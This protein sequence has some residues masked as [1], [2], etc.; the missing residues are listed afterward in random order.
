[1]TRH[2]HVGRLTALAGLLAL[3]IGFAVPAGAA[4]AGNPGGG[5]QGTVKIDGYAVDSTPESVT[6]VIVNSHF[7][8]PVFGSTA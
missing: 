8:S 3:G 6:S 1:M 7:R 2:P 5:N 4:P